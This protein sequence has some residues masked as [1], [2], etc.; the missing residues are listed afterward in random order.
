MNRIGQDLKLIDMQLPVYVVNYTKCSFTSLLP[1]KFI[2]I[3]HITMPN[4]LI[5]L[6]I[7]KQ[8][9]DPMRGKIGHP[10]HLLKVSCSLGTS[11]RA[12]CPYPTTVVSEN[13]P[14]SS[15]FR[16]RSSSTALYQLLRVGGRGHD[17]RRFWLDQG[18]QHPQWASYRPQSVT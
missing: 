1:S 9:H 8:S 5:C 2:F 13:I 6:L 4:L 16:Y 3:L 14:I 11:A 17:N 7:D 10:C 18:I 12:S 15:T